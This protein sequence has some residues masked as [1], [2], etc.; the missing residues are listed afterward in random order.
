MSVFKGMEARAG[1]EPANRGFAVL[2]L[3]LGYRARAPKPFLSIDFAP[4]ASKKPFCTLFSFQN[5]KIKTLFCLF[6]F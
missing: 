5:M 6:L 3:P 2:A 1:I 4:R